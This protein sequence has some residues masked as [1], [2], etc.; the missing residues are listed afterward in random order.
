[1]TRKT[2]SRTSNL[3]L[4]FCVATLVLIAVPPAAAQTETVIHSFRSSSVQDGAVPLS[5]VV[6]DGKGALYGSTLAGGKYGDGSVY[7]LTP[8]PV[9]GGAWKQN[10]LYSFTNGH[11]GA[12]PVGS[13]VLGPAGRI[14]G[15]ADCRCG[16]SKVFE[17]SPP[18]HSGSPWTESVIYDFGPGPLG[19]GIGLSGLVADSKGKLYGSSFY[20]GRFKSGSVFRLSRQADGPWVE[21]DLY[22][23]PQYDGGSVAPN[24]L[25][26]NSA[27]TLYGVTASGGPPGINEGTVFSLTPPTS[28][29]GAWTESLLYYFAAY[30]GDGFQP[31][32]NPVLD[33]NGALYGATVTGGLGSGTVFQLAP[34]TVVGGAWTESILYTF[35]NS[36]DGSGP[37]A[38]L[39][40]DSAGALYGTTQFG[41]DFGCSYNGITD[42]CGVAFKL[43]PPTVQGGSGRC[44]PSTP[45]PEAAMAS[46]PGQL[47]C[48]LSAQPSTGPPSPAEGAE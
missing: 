9:Q 11:D 32:G 19:T 7:R 38:G 30:A 10:I 21:R 23:F 34:P 48:S 42:G 4:A 29:S 45:S 18:A 36:S 2:R 16:S 37:A 44:K 40:L 31:V 8:P 17:I 5:G 28:G 13:L 15:T 43:I 41:G 39:V 33:A 22:S 3:I 1:M 25:V 46:I 12:N 6:A 27:G 35:Q 47:L 20:G 24:G 26:L 14:Y